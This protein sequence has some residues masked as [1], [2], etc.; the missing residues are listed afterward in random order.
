[1]LLRIVI[2]ITLYLMPNAIFAMEK[3]FYAL[4]HDYGSVLPHANLIDILI[5]QGY[6]VRPNGTIKGEVNSQLIAESDLK[7]FRL[8]PLVTNSKFDQHA[9]HKFLNNRLA[10]RKAIDFLVAACK[11]NRLYGLQIDFENIAF[12]D[13]KLFTQFYQDLAQQL[14]QQGFAISVAIVPRL[15]DFKGESAYQ[16]SKYVNWR[17]AYNYSALEKA[18]NF[19]T[20]MTY[21]QHEGATT[22]GPIAAVPWVEAS[23]RY[24]LKYIPSNKISLGIPTYSGHWVTTRS[25]KYIAAHGYQIIHSTLAELIKKYRITLKW[26]EH[27]KIYYAFFNRNELN[28]FIFAENSYTFKEKLELVKKYNLR[29]MS[30]WRLGAEDPGVWKYIK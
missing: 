22:P 28:E 29:G 5:P 30:V 15:S 14:H 18:S 8:M 1:M 9:L 7:H 21:D 16:H 3:T 26:D 20:L 4:R 12:S 17:G 2:I 25:G 6:V 24:A 10:K 23:I 13:Q 11:N 19:V 27:G